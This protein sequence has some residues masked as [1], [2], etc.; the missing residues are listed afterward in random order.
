M[1]QQTTQKPNIISDLTGQSTLYLGSNLNEIMEDRGLI[2]SKKIIA[3]PEGERLVK[4][5]I[6][7]DGR[8][9]VVFTTR[10]NLKPKKIYTVCGQTLTEE[11]FN[12]IFPIVNVRDMSVRD[13]FMDYKPRKQKEYELK[14]ELTKLLQIRPL[15]NFRVAAID[16]SFSDVYLE[17]ME[18]LE[19]RRLEGIVREDYAYKLA[20][21]TSITFS[22]G[23]QPA[24]GMSAEW[25]EA[26]AKDIMPEKESGIAIT[27]QNV[28]VLGACIKHLVEKKNCPIPTAWYYVCINSKEI[29]FYY[30]SKCNTDKKN[31]AFHGTGSMPLG[32]FSDLAGTTKITKDERTGIYRV[33]RG[34]RFDRG[35]DSPLANSTDYDESKCYHS[36][37]LITM[38][39]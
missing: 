2:L 29:A 32:K 37:G 20:N 15:D 11:E 21:A 10:D 1:T 27:P 6:A 35:K 36:V 31:P 7:E 19:K 17:K 25:W 16:P 18:E 3:C 39:V 8:S 5:E 9:M 26:V 30:D 13:S 24:V 22:E 33:E 38:N 4:A 28:A 34:C 14:M 23:R 12:R